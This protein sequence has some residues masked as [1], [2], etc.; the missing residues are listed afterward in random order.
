VGQDD[1]PRA[2]DPC[3]SG[4]SGDDDAPL[5]PHCG[6]DL[7]GHRAERCSECGHVIDWKAL[8]SS[9]FPWAHRRRIGRVRAYVTTVW[10]ISILSRK[11]RYEAARPQRARDGRSFRSITAC[12]LAAAFVGV[13]CVVVGGHGLVLFAIQPEPPIVVGF[14]V[15]KWWTDLAVPWSAGA[16]IPGVLPG[17]LTLLAVHLCSAHRRLFRHK[18]ASPGHWQRADAVAS[19]SI[20]P[21]VW[22]WP[23]LIAAAYVVYEQVWGALWYEST[24]APPRG[25]GAA[26][27]MG[28]LWA[29][30]VIAIWSARA[31]RAGWGSAL[32]ALPSVVILWL[33]GVVVC[34][35]ILPWCVGFVWIVIDSFR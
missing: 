1:S 15:P 7:R 28:T 35:G 34:L 8:Q 5:C 14:S 33:F 17:A 18:G 25:I 10:L 12:I 24:D 22:L 30:W 13:F 32:L 19:Y 23:A 21:L 31:R 20:A 29:A 2:D 26:G 11:L 9:G 4:V 3:A 27:A 6:Y 16:T